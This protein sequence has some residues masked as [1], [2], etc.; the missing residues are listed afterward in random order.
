MTT[1]QATTGS[2]TFEVVNPATR[3]VAGS[4]PVHTADDVAAAV[5]QAREAQRW[6]AALGFAGRQ[7]Y[8]RRW[9]RWLALHCD[10][11]YE[12]GHRETAQAPGGRPV[13]AVRRAGGCP[14]GRGARPA[15]PP[16]AAGRPGHRH[17]ELRRAPVL[18]SARRGRRDH[19]VELA[20]LPDRCPGWLRA[21]AAGNAVV[22]K[23]SELSPASAI[24]RY[25]GLP[26]GQPGCARRAWS[27]GSPASGRP[28]RRCAPPAWTNSPSPARRRPGGG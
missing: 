9:L 23:P 10:E 17:D 18:P 15:G 21:L 24:Y 4:Y 22:V 6:W 16:R 26:P 12:I 25:R 14:L 20:G 5:A 27:A 8:L 19:A 7:P 13:R 11:V 28:A 2:G 1:T 3:E